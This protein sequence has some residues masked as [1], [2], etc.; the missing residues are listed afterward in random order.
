MFPRSPYQSWCTVIVALLFFAACLWL[1][2]QLKKRR[3]FA[4]SV[5]AEQEAVARRAA[6][7]SAPAPVVDPEETADAQ[8]ARFLALVPDT[9]STTKPDLY[10]WQQQGL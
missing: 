1:G 3:E 6:I 4:R 10:D 7:T 8:S 2:R 5:A 9:T